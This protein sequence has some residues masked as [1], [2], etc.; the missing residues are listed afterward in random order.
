MESDMSYVLSHS[1]G[2]SQDPLYL[3]SALWQPVGE[4]L[5]LLERKTI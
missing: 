5:V 2:E 3:I 4:V 1:R